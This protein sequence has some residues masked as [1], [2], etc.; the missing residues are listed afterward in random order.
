MESTLGSPKFLESD[1]SMR[2]VMGGMYLY[3]MPVMKT[4]GR[5][6]PFQLASRSFSNLSTSSQSSRVVQS[7]FSHRMCLPVA[8]ALRRVSMCRKFG[9]QMIS[10]STKSHCIKASS[11]AKMATLGCA[12]PRSRTASCRAL[13][14]ESATAVTMASFWPSKEMFRMCS[15]PMAPVPRMPALSGL[16][17]SADEI[18]GPLSA[19]STRRG[20]SNV[21][22][23]CITVVLSSTRMSPFFQVKATSF[24]LMN[25]ATA[26]IASAFTGDPSPRTT[27]FSPTFLESFQPVKAAT[28]ELKKT[29]RPVRSSFRKAGSTA[30]TVL[31]SPLGSHSQEVP[32]LRM[33]ASASARL[34]TANVSAQERP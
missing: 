24:S 8:M 22:L 16:T 17:P 23:E 9:V 3:S 12:S 19:A 11:S 27:A 15:L 18:G 7:G 10:T 5:P 2:R 13:A 14:S 21:C 29:C 33:A 25:R 30:V 6:G 34:E 28:I 32:C 20:G 26:L 4:P 31:Q 1:S